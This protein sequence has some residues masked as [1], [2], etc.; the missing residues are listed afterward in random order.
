VSSRTLQLSESLHRYLLD[1]TVSEPE[2]LRELRLETEK[3]PHAGMQISP[4]Q[5]RLMRWLVELTG[6]R[7][8][9]EVGVFTGYSALSVALGLPEDGRLVACDLSDEWTSIARRYFAR[10]G[11][12][13]KVDLRLGPALETL[14]QLLGAGAGGA[15][16][17]AF[18]DADKENYAAYYER[19][20]TLL[21]PGGVVAVD[22][23]LWG[24]S[25][26][27]PARDDASTRAIRELNARV[28]GDE[29]VSA[30]LVPIGDGLLLARKR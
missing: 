30:T 24:G 17:F 8:A 4:E 15:Y 25:V 29:R 20:L 11:V 21:R 3:L 27:D 19:C 2:L 5:G 6:A 26:A 13:H 28:C 23:A 7:R 18:I 22:N 14:D 16:D 1:V 10:A 9:L 12:A